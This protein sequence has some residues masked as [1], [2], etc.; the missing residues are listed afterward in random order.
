MSWSRMVAPR[1]VVQDQV[2]S[3]KV[4]VLMIRVPDLCHVENFGLS[5]NPDASHLFSFL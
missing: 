5:L 4:A 1:L 3:C 2:G